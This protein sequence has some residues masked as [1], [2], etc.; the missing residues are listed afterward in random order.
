MAK[1]PIILRHFQL[2]ISYLFY[3][4]VNCNLPIQ[5]EII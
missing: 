2:E 3:V 4:G 5:N 1:Q